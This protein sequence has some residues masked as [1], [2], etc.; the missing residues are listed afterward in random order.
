MRLA[1]GGR[2]RAGDG[3]TPEA[4]GGSLVRPSSVRPSATINHQPSTIDPVVRPSVRPSSVR[5]PSVRD[6]QLSTVNCQLRRPSVRAVDCRLST[7][8]TVV[9]PSDRDHQPSTINHQPRRPSTLLLLALLAPAP[10]ADGPSRERLPGSPS[11]PIRSDWHLRYESLEGEAARS[12]LDAAI[13]L[14]RK[15]LGEPAIPIRTVHL[16]RSVP[17]EEGAGVRKGFQLTEI[18]DSEKGVFAIYLSARPGDAAFAG[19]VAHEG[20]HLFNARL[21]DVY[22]EGLNG[23]LA[24]ELLRERGL[25]WGIWEK[26]F[27]DGRE[28]LYGG[29]FFLVRELVREVGAEGMMALLR[30]AVDSPADPAWMEIDIDRWLASLGPSLAARAR[31]VIARRYDGLEAVRR[32]DAREMSFRRPRDP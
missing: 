30:F 18:A 32:R 15:R 27:R 9:R 7:V 21:R 12:L 13:A 26:H 24:E 4:G 6:C 23:V 31:A 11:K 1:A 10:A 29:S 8:D 19:Q 17:L 5:R 22:V 14:G 3:R 20:F 25:D 28:P 16:R 2:R